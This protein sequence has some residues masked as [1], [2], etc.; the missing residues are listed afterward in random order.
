MHTRFSIKEHPNPSANIFQSRYAPEVYLNPSNSSKSQQNL[1]HHIII[2]GRN[3][4]PRD[5]SL[6]FICPGRDSEGNGLLMLLAAHRYIEEEKS[7]HLLDNCYQNQ[8]SVF[9]DQ[10]IFDRKFI[11][12]N[13]TNNVDSITTVNNGV[14]VPANVTAPVP[15]YRR[16]SFQCKA[17]GCMFSGLRKY[18]IEHFAVRHLDLSPF[19]CRWYNCRKE[20]DLKGNR[21][22]HVYSSHIMGVPSTQCMWTGCLLVFKSESDLKAHTKNTHLQYTDEEAQFVEKAREILRL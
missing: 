17:E 8:L 18:F 3:T 12:K 10:E 15:H 11:A 20:F 22:R 13:E 9:G 2:S 4:E 14:T 6:A 19:S 7:E 1:Y 21:D 5:R 16:F